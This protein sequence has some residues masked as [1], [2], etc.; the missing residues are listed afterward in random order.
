MK[1]EREATSNTL[2]YVTLLGVEMG[3]ETVENGTV[4]IKASTAVQHVLRTVYRDDR[5]E[6]CFHTTIVVTLVTVHP[7]P[8]YSSRILY[9]TRYLRER[10]SCH[11]RV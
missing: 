8:P 9:L 10:R 7:V 6:T 11:E 2:L 3:M 1:H 5:T 4:M